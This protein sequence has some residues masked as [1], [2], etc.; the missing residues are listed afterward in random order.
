[1]RPGISNDDIFNICVSI[2][3]GRHSRLTDYTGPNWNQE[4]DRFFV[5]VQT[6]K[7]MG[8]Y[9]SQY[10][11]RDTVGGHITAFLWDPETETVAF[12]EPREQG[13]AGTRCSFFVR[14]VDVLKYKAGPAMRGDAEGNYRGLF[15]EYA[16]L[17][18][19]YNRGPL[20]PMFKQV[21]GAIKSHKVT[22]MV[23]FDTVPK[24]YEGEASS[25][26]SGAF[27]VPDFI[28]VPLNGVEARYYPEQEWINAQTSAAA[29]MGSNRWNALTDKDRRHRI[30]LQLRFMF[31]SMLHPSVSDLQ[32][33]HG[34]VWMGWDEEAAAGAAAAAGAGA[35]APMAEARD[36]DQ[37]PTP[38]IDAMEG[39]GMPQHMSRGDYHTKGINRRFQ[40]DSPTM[41]GSGAAMSTSAMERG[42]THARINKTFQDLDLKILDLKAAYRQDAE[43]FEPLHRI[44]N[45]LYDKY[46]TGQESAA[47]LEEQFKLLRTEIT[48]TIETVW[49][50]IRHRID[51][52]AARL[53]ERIFANQ[54]FPNRVMGW[55]DVDETPPLH[56]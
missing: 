26:S 5:D 37:I 14:H 46:R 52:R 8:Y 7:R 13:A 9:T 15:G 43:L 30:N 20:S 35:A 23:I 6:H 42:E 17:N 1:M 33:Q 4:L 40:Y 39:Q 44:L 32:S 22:E 53:D 18:T 36:E 29:K 21:E 55:H 48:N 3:G 51:I 12:F 34:G 16:I 11:T 56:Q 25:A 24:I 27:H 54:M 19:A 31:P 49:D 47:T 2:I 28:R 41:S 38:K 10:E 50:R 45:I